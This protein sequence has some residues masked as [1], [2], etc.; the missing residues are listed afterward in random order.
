MVEEENSKLQQQIREE[1][2][3]NFKS[4][5]E[6]VLSYLIGVID[7]NKDDFQTAEDIQEATGAILGELSNGENDDEFIYELCSKFLDILQW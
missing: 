3:R 2:E 6:E 4:I 5:D 7:L 1:L